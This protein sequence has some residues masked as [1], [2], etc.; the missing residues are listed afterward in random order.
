MQQRLKQMLGLSFR[1]PLL[2]ARAL[3]LLDDARGF[4]LI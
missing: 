3:K 2:C 1:F 4:S